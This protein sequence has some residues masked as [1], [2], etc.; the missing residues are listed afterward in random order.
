[1]RAV[2]ICAN[3]AHILA[4]EGTELPEVAFIVADDHPM[5]RDALALALRA[6]FPK[7]EV[8]LAG[9]LDEASAAL[10]ARP[11]VDLVILDLD[12]STCRACRGWP[13]SPRCV[14]AIP[15]RHW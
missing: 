4:A 13:A 3:F 6:A 15:A 1:V 8:A 10:A 12:T 2:A 14:R 9:T 7:A 5:V 11:D